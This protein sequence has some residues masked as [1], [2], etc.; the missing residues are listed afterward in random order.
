MID[1]RKGVY[2]NKYIDGEQL[3][4]QAAILIEDSSYFSSIK[5]PFFKIKNTVNP[6]G[7]SVGMGDCHT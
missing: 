5:D 3:W 2:V 6:E 7:S 4:V 1:I